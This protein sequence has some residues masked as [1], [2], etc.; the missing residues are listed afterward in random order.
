ME[1]GSLSSEYKNWFTFKYFFPTL[2]IG[3]YIL[4]VG[5]PTC[6]SH[7]VFTSALCIFGLC[8]IS[9]HSHVSSIL[10]SSYASAQGL[11]AIFTTISEFQITRFNAPEMYSIRWICMLLHISQKKFSLTIS[12]LFFATFFQGKAVRHSIT[13]QLIFACVIFICLKHQVHFYHSFLMSCSS[14]DWSLFRMRA[15]K[16]EWLAQKPNV[17]PS[18]YRYLLI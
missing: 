15:I 5:L 2:Y 1:T 17:A 9:Q 10:L 11:R 7:S 6:T 16:Y 18:C 8:S 4:S 13:C 14:S 3:C 12:P